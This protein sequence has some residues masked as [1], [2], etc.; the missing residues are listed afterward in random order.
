MASVKADDS[1]NRRNWR[2][3]AR[4]LMLNL[5]K[6]L[7]ALQFLHRENFVKWQDDV[8]DLSPAKVG[9]H[10]PNMSSAASFLPNHGANVRVRSQCVA[11]GCA[12]CRCTHWHS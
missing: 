11:L 12:Y 1:R 4:R 3:T 8:S 10:M 5:S 2:T 6:A 9:D 7:M